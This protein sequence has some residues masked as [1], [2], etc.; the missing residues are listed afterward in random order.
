MYILLSLAPEH[1]PV[2]EW[3]HAVYLFT[4]YRAGFTAID[5]A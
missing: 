4:L 2:I 3:H 1:W 5:T